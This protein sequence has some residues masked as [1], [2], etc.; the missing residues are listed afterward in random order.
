MRTHT[1]THNHG[2]SLAAALRSRSGSALV[3]LALVVPCL[4]VILLGA[5]EFAMLA[6]ESIEVSD[7]AHAAAAYGSESAGAAGDTTGIR[8]VAAASANDISGVV[9]T[10]TVFYSC[11]STPATQNTTPP[12][13]CSSTDSV[14]TYIQVTT[15]ATVTMPIHIRGIGIYT[16][17]GL[18]IMRVR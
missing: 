10:P 16:L 6:Y 8:S 3:E 4:V 1:T 7:A 13:G 15:S 12:T 11:S 14:L 5:V 2:T 18:A 17:N 9:T